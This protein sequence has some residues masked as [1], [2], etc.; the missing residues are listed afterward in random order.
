MVFKN[1]SF[2]VLGLFHWFI[3]SSFYETS[4]DNI[5]VKSGLW[6]FSKWIAL[7]P[8][9]KLFTILMTMDFAEEKINLF[10]SCCTAPAN[11]IPLPQAAKMVTWP[12]LTKWVGKRFHRKIL[13]VPL[14]LAPC[15]CLSVI[16]ISARMCYPISFANGLCTIYSIRMNTLEN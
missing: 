13:V 8:A 2:A 3:N 9:V 11:S 14:L 16:F 1:I 15:S 12:T 6:L 10:K 4:V 7:S 5:L